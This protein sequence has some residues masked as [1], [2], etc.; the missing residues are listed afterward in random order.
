M[1]DA[2]MAPLAFVAVFFI[3]SMFETIRARI[4]QRSYQVRPRS[5]GL[6]PSL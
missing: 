4:N 1:T 6:Q 2:Q 5:K 3:V